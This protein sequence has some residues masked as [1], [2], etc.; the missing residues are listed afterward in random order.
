MGCAVTRSFQVHEPCSVHGLQNFFDLQGL[1]RG[2]LL[3]A[4][5]GFYLVVAVD[6]N[7]RRHNDYFSALA[8]R[9]KRRN[10]LHR[11]IYHPVPTGT[12]FRLNIRG[13]ESFERE[14]L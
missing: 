10:E 7:R 14:C 5:D 4:V 1:D 2:F 13:W 11:T 3:W 9:F 12:P 8:D 6:R